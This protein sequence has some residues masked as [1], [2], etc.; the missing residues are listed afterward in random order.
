MRCPASVTITT[1]ILS[2]FLIIG[3]GFVAAIS[4]SPDSLPEKSLS[5]SL[6]VLRVDDADRDGAGL[7]QLRSQRSVPETISSGSTSSTARNATVCD[8][9]CECIKEYSLFLNIECNFTSNK[10]IVIVRDNGYC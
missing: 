6:S 9:L 1:V 2:V 4:A 10:V 3:G 5:P 8:E 7:L